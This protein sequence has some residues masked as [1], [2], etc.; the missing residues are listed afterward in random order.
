MH[1][2]CRSVTDPPIRLAEVAARGR[3]ELEKKLRQLL[4]ESGDPD[5]VKV[6][7]LEGWGDWSKEPLPEFGGATPAVLLRNPEDQRVVENLVK[8]MRGGLAA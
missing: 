4:A 8:R 6:L 3:F 7:D 2:H 5:R 1:K